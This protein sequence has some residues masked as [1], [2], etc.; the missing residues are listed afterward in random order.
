MTIRRIR[1]TEDDMTIPAALAFDRSEY[2]SR[3]TATREA[4]MRRGIDALVTHVPSNMCYLAGFSTL[5]IYE[6]AC[7]IVP[8]AGEPV[9]V[10]RALEEHTA[11]HRCWLSAIETY[12]DSDEPT[13][14]AA[15]AILR[16]APR[17]KVA[18]ERASAW[19]SPAQYGR[20]V[21]AIGEERVVAGDGVI[22]PLRLVKSAAEIAYLRDSA[23]ATDASMTAGIDAVRHGAT[24]NDVAIAMYRGAIAAG[25]EYPSNPPAV[26]S[27]PRSGLPHSTWAGRRIEPGE[28]V[29]LVTSASIQRYTTAIFRVATLGSA[30]ADHR[31]M[32]ETVTRGLEAAQRAMRPGAVSHEIDALCHAEFERAGFGEY[33]RHRTAYSMGISFPP[34]VGEVAVGTIRKGSDL[35]LREG[36]VFHVCPAL[37]IPGVVGIGI[38]ET[39]LVTKDG[40]QM[41]GTLPRRIAEVAA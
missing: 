22:E 37:F 11:R 17:G 2:E 26:N 33:H 7:L 9:L 20:L 19:L 24:E 12:L 23:R 31:R 14:S 5:G 18:L 30:S 41:L 39:V 28:P 4:M 15:A 32:A 21:A 34:H 16:A 27:G 10:V 13:A 36:M 1:A 6:Y 25:S 29:Y 40:S 8:L 38:T 35:V 3:V